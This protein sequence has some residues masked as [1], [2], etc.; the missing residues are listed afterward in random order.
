MLVWFK[1]TGYRERASER[2]R[3]RERERERE[4]HWRFR[5]SE[6]VWAQDKSLCDLELNLPKSLDSLL[7]ILQAGLLSSGFRKNLLR[8]LWVHQAMTQASWCPPG[9]NNYD[10]TT[11]YIVRDRDRDRDV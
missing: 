2:A 1:S 8:Y 9:S 6:K 4:T 5:D 3:E 11:T 7:G 10:V